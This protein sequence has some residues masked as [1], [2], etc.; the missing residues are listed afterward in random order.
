MQIEIKET[1]IKGCVELLPKQFNDS[2]GKFV[3]T[4]HEQ[5]FEELHLTTHFAEEYYSVSYNNVL[6]GLHFQTPP[7]DHIKVVYCLD[8]EVMDVVVDLRKGSPTY[9]KHDIIGLSSKKANMLYIP[10]GMAHGFY[11]IS[12]KAVMLYKVTTVYDHANDTGIRWDS[13]GIAWP[14]KEPVISERDSKFISFNE[15]NSPFTI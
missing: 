7:S 15:F 4:F 13:C 11:T 6:R 12:E 3:K 9:G 8:G 1:T 5:T 14:S 10:S 2:R